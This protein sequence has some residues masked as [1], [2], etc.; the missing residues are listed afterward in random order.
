VSPAS[1]RPP[2][3]TR[4]RIP[5]PPRYPYGYGA[6]IVYAYPL[7]LGPTYFD[8]SADEPDDPSGAS[9]PPADTDTYAGLDP[10][11]FQPP[12]A[13]EIP[14]PSPEP[15]PEAPDAVTL[16]F[17]DGRPAQQVHNY[18]LTRTTLYVIGSHH[19]DIPVADLDLAATEKANRQ[20]GVAFELPGSP[21]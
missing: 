13:D 7:W 18:A 20:A 3:Y 1:A 10:G 5:H 6:G 4:N 21:Q 8:D 2:F 11:Q 19:R 12:L 14:Q 16:I 17:K 9:V 15:A